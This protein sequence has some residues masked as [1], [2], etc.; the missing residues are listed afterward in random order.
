MSEP[1]GGS[2]VLVTGGRGFIGRHVVD[3]LEERGDH[4]VVA[5]HPDDPDPGGIRVDLSDR[6]AVVDVAR[7]VDAIRTVGRAIARE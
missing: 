1:F 6:D 3:A 4:V 7:G 5:V 2:R